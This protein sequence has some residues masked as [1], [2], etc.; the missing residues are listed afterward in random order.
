MW[1]HAVGSILII[2]TRSSWKIQ[3]RVQN[4]EF[5]LLPKHVL[6]SSMHIKWLLYYLRY[7]TKCPDL[8]W[9]WLKVRPDCLQIFSDALGCPKWIYYFR[10]MYFCFFQSLLSG[11]TTNRTNDN[12]YIVYVGMK[13]K[14]YNLC[15]PCTS[16]PSWT[17]ALI[18]PP[19]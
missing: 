10:Y 7:S 11:I 18:G 14:Y 3:I 1:W 2:R 9:K 5:A 15:I 17:V 19:L 4:T 6:K 12:N 16:Y 13:V 8:R